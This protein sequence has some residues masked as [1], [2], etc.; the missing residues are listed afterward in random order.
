MGNAVPQDAD[1]LAAFLASGTVTNG[2]PTAISAKFRGI[3][4]SAYAVQIGES[5]PNPST[6][7]CW[8]KQGGGTALLTT[9]RVDVLKF[10]P[11]GTVVGQPNYGKRLVNDT[12]LTDHGK[13]PHSVSLP[14]SG[15]GNQLPES[16]GA[17]IVAV[18]RHPDYPVDRYRAVGGV[19]FQTGCRDD[20]ADTLR[21]L[22]AS[23]RRNR[24]ANAVRQQRGAQS[25]RAI[26][27]QQR[28]SVNANLS[29]ALQPI[30]LEPRHRSAA[31]GAWNSPV[32][33]WATPPPPPGSVQVKKSQWRFFT[34][35][36]RKKSVW[37][38]VH[39]NS[40]SPSR[41]PIETA[42]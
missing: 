16:A 25:F 11:L 39:F 26:Q 23:G 8:A 13:S 42:S 24:K 28:G 32:S 30:Q 33:T 40:A 2:N 4:V 41:T 34:A 20:V 10:L 37:R 1:I 29:A 27:F 7:P 35:T 5:D 12:D 3:D 22:S 21:L 14:D 31:S 6:A 38:S 18:Y 9:W 17:G 19:P 15:T 36:S